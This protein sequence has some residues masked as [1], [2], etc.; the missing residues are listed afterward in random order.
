MQIHNVFFIILCLL[1]AIT[2]IYGCLSR[3]YEKVDN[4]QHIDITQTTEF[5]D[6]KIA[7]IG[8]KQSFSNSKK[9][10]FRIIKNYI[11]SQAYIDTTQKFGQNL[12]RKSDIQASANCFLDIAEHKALKA[13]CPNFVRQYNKSDL[14]EKLALSE[15][16]R[17]IFDKNGAYY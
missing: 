5:L 13:L 7:L 17:C 14:I 3:G 9:K 2:T 10:A 8:C 16:E 4:L 11:T 6:Q 12:I 15:Y 1:S